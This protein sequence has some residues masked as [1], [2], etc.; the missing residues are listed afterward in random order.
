MMT[1]GIYPY[2]RK[3][4]DVKSLTVVQNPMEISSKSHWNAK[5]IYAKWW[6]SGE[7]GSHVV[8]FMPTMAGFTQFTVPNCEL[9]R[10]ARSLWEP[11][12]TRLKNSKN[13]NQLVPHSHVCWFL[14]PIGSN[15]ALRPRTRNISTSSR[16]SM[17]PLPSC[18]GHSCKWHHNSL[19]NLQRCIPNY[20]KL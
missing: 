7:N 1:G 19:W 10:A 20:K 8:F 6:S 3:P 9:L 11:N 15:V 4:Q 12:L 17:R 16:R 14:Q 2:F 13:L 18:W 5:E